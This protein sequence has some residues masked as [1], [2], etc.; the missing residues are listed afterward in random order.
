MNICLLRLC[1]KL[2]LLKI[3]KLKVGWQMFYR[4]M[5][6]KSFPIC[7]K[8]FKIRKLYRSYISLLLV[9]YSGS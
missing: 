6:A 7:L 4:R 3:E 9:I 1:L 8:L 2:K 5:R